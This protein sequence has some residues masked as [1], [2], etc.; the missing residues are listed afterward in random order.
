MPEISL[1]PEQ[2]VYVV[3]CDEGASCF[4]FDNARD[5]TNQIAALLQRPDLA[6]GPDDHGFLAGY[7]KYGQAVH[8]WSCSPLASKTYFDPG[9]DPKVAAVL[10]RCRRG[11]TQ[12][13]LMLGDTGTGES[14]LDEY[15]V[16]G[17]IGRSTGLLKVPLLVEPGEDGGPAILTACV[18]A[19]VE[20]HTGRF[21]YR[22]PALQLPELSI[23][24]STE[25][26]YAWDVLRDT[27]VIARFRD[28]AQAG[29]YVAFMR[30]ATLEPRVFR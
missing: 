24:P 30:G 8:A 27:N 7:E 3:S 23:A 6:F 4:G 1:N 20:W 13:R 10:E 28:I 16:V 18:L 25:R 29:G 12:V 22:H 17:H 2:R 14:W 21:F 26:G 11:G 9:T 19:V 5:H 15:D